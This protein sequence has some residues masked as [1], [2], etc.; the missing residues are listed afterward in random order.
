MIAFHL[1][2]CREWFICLIRSLHDLASAKH[3]DSF[4]DPRASRLRAGHKSR[5]AE[6]PLPEN[7]Q[8]FPK[9]ISHTNVGIFVATLT[10]EANNLS[11]R[12]GRE[13]G[14]HERRGAKAPLSTGVPTPNKLYF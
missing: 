5:H 1:T 14:M 2:G 13:V 9:P 7:R 10:G 12:E 4:I 6:E 8:W 3:D 11:E